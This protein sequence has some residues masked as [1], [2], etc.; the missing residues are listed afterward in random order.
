MFE[1]LALRASSLADRLGKIFGDPD[2]PACAARLQEE[3]FAALR[4]NTPGMMLANIGNALALLSTFIDTP[5]A[6]RVALWTDALLLVSVYIYLRAR[7]PASGVRKGPSAP[8]SIGRRAAVNAAIL[9]A[10]WAAVPPLFFLE[11]SPGARL[12]VISLTA[13]MLFGGAFALA[14]APLAAT[15][16]SGPIAATAAA[17]LIAGR[18]PDLTRIAVVL[19]IYTAVLLRN[20]YVE[21]EGFRERVLSQMGAEREAR[22]DALTGL[23]NRLAFSDAIERELARARRYGGGFMLL[24]VDIDNFKTINDRYG[25]PAGDELLME[26]ARRMRASLRASDLVARLGGDEFAIIA[27]DVPGPEAARAIARRVVSCF[28]EPFQLEG[29]AVQGAASVGGAVAPID[30]ADQRTLFKSADVALYQ[31]KQCGGWRLFEPVDDMGTLDHAA[32]GRTRPNADEVIDSQG[33]E[34]A[35]CEKPVPAFSPR[36]L[37]APLLEQDLRRALSQGQ[38]SL[39]FQPI[40]NLATGA[41][42]GF[43]ALLRWR[44]PTRGDIPPGAFLPLAEECGLIHDIGLWVLEAACAPAARFSDQLRLCVNVSPVQLSRPDFAAR[45]LEAVARG[46]ISPCRL[47]IEIT[48]KAMLA[49]D[50]VCAEQVRA[51]SRAGVTISLDDFGSGYASLAQFGKLP[52]DRVKIDGPL[53][54]EAPIRKDCAAIVSGVVR[55]AK[56]FHIGVVA[57]GVETQEQLAWLR[58]IGADEA[59]GYLIAAPMPLDRLEPFILGWRL[60]TLAPA[61]ANAKLSA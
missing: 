58:G 30:G 21:A 25:H 43:E 54:R 26:A 7:R 15:V 13:G 23:P 61:E 38:F 41:I 8:T 19:I 14:R 36:A 10:L 24:C 31:A 53:A 1:A 5:L 46:K 9:G 47:E 32:F 37:D 17:T 51:M 40:V 57:E 56:G 48:E 45:A 18:D 42:S 49:D 22:T 12:M 6:P 4:Q 16:F 27:T 20:V 3:Q 2:D 28:A 39:A 52:L 44:H 50:P 60:E 11:A 55:M 29:Q 35:S 34:R 33:L 59:Q